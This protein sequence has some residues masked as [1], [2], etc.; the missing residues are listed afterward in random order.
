MSSPDT[1]RT[2]H[3]TRAVIVGLAGNAVL[4]TAKVTAG[5][6]SGSK[7]VLAD[8]ID[9]A[10][11]VLISIVSLVAARVMAAPSDETH[12]FG[13][14]RAE[15]IATN[16]LACVIF[17][18]GVQ[19]AIN[20][21]SELVAGQIR[22][23]PSSLAI[24]VTA[25]SIAGKL[26]LAFHQ[27]RAGR[28]TDSGMLVANAVNMRNDVLMSVTVLVG[29]IFTRGFHL[30]VLDSIFA[31]L[32]SAFIIRTAILIF[33]DV[34]VELMDGNSD[35]ALY[36]RLFAAVRRVEGAANPHR[37]RIRKMGNQVVI[38]VDVEVNGQL[39]VLE[40]HRIATQVEKSIKSTLDNVYD[41]M[42]HV[43]PAG[44]AF[45]HEPE[46]YGLNEDCLQREDSCDKQE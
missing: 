14:G 5:I 44:I 32:V 41:V 1:L 13:H 27:Y 17:F 19:L 3:I 22:A 36:Q 7:A 16:L 18:V 8:G 26:L 4:A 25:F 40:A 35:K 2:R 43:E 20:T 21:V 10:S 45:D 9:S 34:N 42:V 38:D 46:C 6:I 15:T 24:W 33:I 28:S 12:P 11:D 29:L 30:P 37:A 31:L 23:A 39:T